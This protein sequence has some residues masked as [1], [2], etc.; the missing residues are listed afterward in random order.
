MADTN[1]AG[2]N[3]AANANAAG[4]DNAWNA[5][6]ATDRGGAW[7]DDKTKGSEEK[8]KG[9]EMIPSYRLKEEADKRRE[10]EDKHT[11]AAAKLAEYEEKEKKEQEKKQREQGKFDEILA[12]KDKEIETLKSSTAK[13]TEYDAI[14]Q[15]TVTSELEAIEKSITKEKLDKILTTIWFAERD[16]L[17]QL[18]ALTSVKSLVADLTPAVP[19]AKGWSWMKTPNNAN[20]EE[21]KKGWFNEMFKALFVG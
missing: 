19:S 5:N 15:A 4:G 9:S 1:D 20:L 6:T 12:W 11:A 14:V 21:A 3:P 18:A 2:Q 7:G 13:L 16:T 10:A 8:D 17:W